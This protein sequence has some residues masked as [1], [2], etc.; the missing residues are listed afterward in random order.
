MPRVTTATAAAVLGLSTKALDNIL[1]RSPSYEAF[2]G[3]QGKSRRIDEQT[4][5]ELAV[6]ADLARAFG[7]SL[8]SMLPTARLVC[9]TAG[10]IGAGSVEL[11]VDLGRIRERLATAVE[12][13]IEQVPT[14][15]RG[16]P[17]KQS[18]ALREERPAW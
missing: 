6:A 7:V 9:S 10:A 17:P 1:A 18:G 12:H 3:S 2:R 16:R 8:Q 11:R 15:R 14:P 13:A 5:E 4:L